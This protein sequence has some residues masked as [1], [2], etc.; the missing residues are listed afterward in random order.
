MLMYTFSLVDWNF[1]KFCPK[2]PK[3]SV[4]YV[5]FY[6]FDWKC[7]FWAY[8]LKNEKSLFKLKFDSKTD[9]NVPNLMVIF[10]FLFSDFFSF[11][12]EKYSF[13]GQYGPIT[14]NCM[15]KAKF[16]TQT[17]SNMLSW[18]VLFTF[19]NV[20]RHCPFFLDKFSTKT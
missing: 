5:H 9:W 8:G 4:C 18:M 13:V 2:Q 17:N 19:S 3:L 7:L 11:S 16:G 10:N 20:D 1:G 6:R 15:F 12:G 14:Q